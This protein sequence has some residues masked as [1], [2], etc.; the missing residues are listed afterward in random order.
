[1]AVPFST[2]F[3]YTFAFAEITLFLQLQFQSQPW[4]HIY[5]LNVKRVK[6]NFSNNNNKPFTPSFFFQ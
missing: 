6:N 1:M 3:L 2:R 4:S 5:A